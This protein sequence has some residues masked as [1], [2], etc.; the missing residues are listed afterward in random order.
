MIAYNSAVVTMT[1]L[2]VIENYYNYYCYYYYCCS[3]VL[4]Y[5]GKLVTAC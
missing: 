3:Q 2:T 5:L 1:I 4:Q